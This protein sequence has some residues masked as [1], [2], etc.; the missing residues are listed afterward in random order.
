MAVGTSQGA[1]CTSGATLGFSILLKDACSSVLPQ[2]AGIRTSHLLI[3]SQPAL[4]AE[5]RPP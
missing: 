2:G 5:L 4:P 1:N 3:T